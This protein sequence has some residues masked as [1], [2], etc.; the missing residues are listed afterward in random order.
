MSRYLFIRW[1]A[2]L[3][4]NTEIKTNGCPDAPNFSFLQPFFKT[5]VC[6]DMVQQERRLPPGDA[7]DPIFLVEKALLFIRRFRIPLFGF[8]LLGLALGISN[9]LFS[10]RLYSSKLLLQSRVLTNKEAIE[11]VEEW[12]DLLEHGEYGALSRITNTDRMLLRKLKKISADEI[13]KL[14]VQNNPNGFSIEVEVIDT[15]ALTSLEAALI[16]GIENTAYVKAKVES[17]RAWFAG[18]I[19]NV[20]SELARLDIT[21]TAVD[22]II[23]RKAI[24]ASSLMVDISSLNG[25]W[26]G[27][28]EKLLSFREELQFTRGV[29]VLQHFMSPEKPSSPKLVKSVIL[30]FAGG[31]FIG[32]T[33]AMLLYIRSR[34]RPRTRLRKSAGKTRFRELQS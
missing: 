20:E 33:A 17:K 24:G 14:Y 31:L 16:Q 30:G 23:R 13:Q 19:S 15:T 8:T 12:K 25:Q 21:R 28:N 10:P 9:Y 22:S 4:F 18:M 34:L 7:A 3:S 27:L 11:I 29:Q 1:T 26:V 2:V 5:F 6:T 32:Y